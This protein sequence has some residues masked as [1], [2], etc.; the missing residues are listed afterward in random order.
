MLKSHG[1]KR[2]ENIIEHVHMLQVYQVRKI[3]YILHI[4]IQKLKQVIMHQLSSKP[5]FQL[6]KIDEII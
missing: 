3:T 6:L 4:L 1:Q 2:I 5:T